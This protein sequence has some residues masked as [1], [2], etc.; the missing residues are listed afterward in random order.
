MKYL[1]IDYGDSKVGLAIADSETGLA[2][3]YKIISGQ[4]WDKLFDQLS[5]I[6]RAE[7]IATVVVG[8]P[9][10]ASSQEASS[11]ESRARKFI[12]S[13]KEKI[14][15]AELVVAD[16]RFSTQAA[17]K[18]GANGGHDDDVAAMVTLQ[19]YLD[20]LSIE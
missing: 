14:T 11:Q 1:G 20:G 18:L 17:K 12:A 8:V 4:D 5:E 19:N 9:V 16:E 2:L 10:N 3:P 15:S 7:R 6:I 13:F